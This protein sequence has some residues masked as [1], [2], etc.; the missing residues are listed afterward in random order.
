MGTSLNQLKYLLRLEDI[1]NGS[2]ISI[3]IL[4]K[5]EKTHF[6]QNYIN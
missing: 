4:I 1:N 6:I 3:E 2:K 5:K